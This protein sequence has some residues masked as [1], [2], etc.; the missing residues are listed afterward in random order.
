MEDILSIITFI[1]PFIFG[2]LAISLIPSK[3]RISKKEITKFRPEV[4]IGV[5]II[6]FVLLMIGVIFIISYF[7]ENKILYLLNAALL[8]IIAVGTM[9]LNSK[10]YSLFSEIQT[11]SETLGRAEIGE[12]AGITEVAKADQTKNHKKDQKGKKETN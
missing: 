5:Y 4:H 6:A 9:A 11:E 8:E 10:N 12:I 2:I 1:V 3:E 7:N